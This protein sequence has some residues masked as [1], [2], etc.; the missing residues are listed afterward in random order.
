[1]HKSSSNPVNEGGHD[2][3]ARWL[4]CT[5]V[6]NE[7]SLYSQHIKV[8]KSIRV[9]LLPRDFNILCQSLTKKKSTLLYHHRQRYHSASKCCPERLSPGYCHKW[10]PRHNRGNCQSQ[11]NQAVCQLVKIVHIPH[12]HKHQEQIPGLN[13]TRIQ[14]NPDVVICSISAKKP[15]WRNK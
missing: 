12:T 4:G 6:S 11:L 7:V 3:V 5:L 2:T 1:M 10:H 9:D 15:V 14:Y 13:P 8:T